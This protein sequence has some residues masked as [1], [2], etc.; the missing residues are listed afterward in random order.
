MEAEGHRGARADPSRASRANLAHNVI[1]FARFLRAN[2]LMVS[3][4]EV[5]DAV[6][7]IRVI[8]LGDRGEFYL[9]LRSV[10][11]WNP[12]QRPL[13]DE[14]F[15]RFW[16]GWSDEESLVREER[17]PT[18]AVARE[19]GAESQPSGDSYSAMEAVIEKDFSDFKPDE[20][21]AVARACVTIARR[22]ATRKSR[23]YRI[24]TRGTRVDP[25]RTIR[26][27]VQFGGTVIELARMERKIRKPRIVVI[28]DV[29]RSMEQYSV[30]LLQFMHSMQN[31]IGR[32]ESFVFS[33]SL[34]HVS[35]YFKHADI[36]TALGEIAADIP[37]WSG[38]TRIGESL[39]TFNESFARRMV[40][41]RTVVM[42]LSDGLDTGQTDLLAEQMAILQKRA[43]RLIWLNPLLGREGYQP[44]ARGMVAALPYVDIFAAAH[45]LASLQKLANSLAAPRGPRSIATQ[46]LAG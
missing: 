14:L 31:V 23:R 21:G 32:I 18:I 34:H 19:E 36:Q 1:D 13:F 24:T 37:D 2:D 35:S 41:P 44:V 30:F 10:L 39:R 45:N 8:D 11:L 5:H 40:D 17:A 29:S 43:A 22:V 4:A 12:D 25:R 38:G 20:L 6:R 9:A 46:R 26:R 16:G 33:T 27:N 28:C 7:A 15:E 3:P 42:I